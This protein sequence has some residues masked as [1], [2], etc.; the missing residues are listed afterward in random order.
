MTNWASACVL[1]GHWHFVRVYRA[2]LEK[3][4]HLSHAYW[5]YNDISDSMFIEQD[6]AGTW[7]RKLCKVSLWLMHD[8]LTRSPSDCHC[9][10][11]K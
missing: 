1:I 4:E 3:L 6:K 7:M 10:S 11:R 9:I 2:F 5:Y 8:P